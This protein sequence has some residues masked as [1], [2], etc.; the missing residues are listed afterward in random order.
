[1]KEGRVTHRTNLVSAGVIAAAAASFC[2]LA[3]MPMANADNP[4]LVGTW[5]GHRERIASTEG[6]RNGEAT[7]TVT[8][9][10]GSTF[11]GALSRTTPAGDVSDPL[12]GAFTPDGTIISG[13]D[14]EGTYTFT[15]VD[16]VTL[17]YCYSEHGP[18]YRTTCARLHK[19]G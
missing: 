8:E 13:A 3:P 12:V 1:M 10:T 6:Y 5:T 18:G 11:K 2:A 15:L 19:E 9:Q 4:D 14:D 17:D 7:L 16:P